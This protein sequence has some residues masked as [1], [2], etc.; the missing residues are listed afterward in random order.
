MRHSRSRRRANSQ[1]D[2]RTA[3]AVPAWPAIKTL[4]TIG[5]RLSTLA[6]AHR[7]AANIAWMS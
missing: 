7:C 4:S 3:A 5:S 1:A 6:D 2:L